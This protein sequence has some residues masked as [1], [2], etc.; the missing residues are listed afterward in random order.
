MKSK[1]IFN[2]EFIVTNLKANTIIELTDCT[3]FGFI[4]F[5][6][7][8][9]PT[10][11]N[12][13]KLYVNYISSDYSYVFEKYTNVFDGLDCVQMKCHLELLENV[14]PSVD[15]PRKVPFKLR[16]LLKAEL[17]KMEAGGVIEKTVV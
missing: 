10:A 11:P 17:E 13:D 15:P 8:V 3:R 2:L 5:D 12:E 6:S 16:K 1:R 9:K 4:N 14:T 7:N